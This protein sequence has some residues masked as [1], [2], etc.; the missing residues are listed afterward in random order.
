MFNDDF[1]TEL[2]SNLV[3]EIKYDFFR[4][5]GKVPY[6]DIPPSYLKELI[7][8]IH[9]MQEE[10]KNKEEYKHSSYCLHLLALFF[11][12][13]RRLSLTQE[14]GDM[15]ID[16][17]EKKLLCQFID[18]V[19]KH[20]KEKLSMFYYAHE[21]KCSE[22]KLNRVC[23]NILKESPLKI[24]NRRKLDEAKR[25]LSFSQETIKAIA[26]ELG[27]PSQPYFIAFFKKHMGICPNDFR[28]KM[29]IKQS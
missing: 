22:S 1:L 3:H 21:L 20:F 25:M 28:D 4:R 13:L 12:K 24:I 17:T 19:E 7:E 6:L 18:L 16:N 11:I 5:Y 27:F 10:C 26:L 15:P 23:R 14:G 8:I 9:L 29:Q 2:D